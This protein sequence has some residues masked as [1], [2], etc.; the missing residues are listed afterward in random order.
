MVDG[1][2]EFTSVFKDTGRHRH[3][4]ELWSDWITCTRIAISNRVEYSEEDA[5]DMQRILDK[6]TQADRGNFESLFQLMVDHC[7]SFDGDFLGQFYMENEF[8]CK[9]MG[10]Y[11][12]PS[13]IT[14]LL[15]E[16]TYQ[17][18]PDRS[19]HPPFLVSDPC[20]GSGA[21]LISIAKK[22][23]SSGENPQKELLF[24]GVDTDFLAAQMAYIQLSLLGLKG[25][26]IHG[27]SLTMSENRRYMTP[28]L[29]LSWNRSQLLES[30]LIGDDMG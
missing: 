21:L 27:N 29:S 18:S 7:L 4:A 12:T 15:A 28:L 14:N 3:R 23:I 26:I 1:Y 6:Y 22:A 24:Y 30:I 13:S 20:C 8:G 9:S 11:Y 25:V 19:G 5:T 17:P 10:A 2:K 16:F